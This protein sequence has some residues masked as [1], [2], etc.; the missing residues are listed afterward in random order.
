MDMYHPV[1]VGQSILKRMYIRLNF[2]EP[3][4]IEEQS[5]LW[6]AN[7]NS[8]AIVVS[9]TPSDM[10]ILSTKRALIPV[11]LLNRSLEGYSYVSIDHAEAGR[12][13]A[14]HAIKKGGSEISLILTSIPLN[15]F[16]AREQAILKTCREFEVDL[17]DK[18][19][20]A[21]GHIDAGYEL[22]CHLVRENRLRKVILCTYDMT[23]LGLISALNES[24]VHVGTDVEVLSTSS[25]LSRLFARFSP[26]MTVVN[27]KM[28]EISQR[29]VRM[30]IDLASGRASENRGVIIHPSIVYRQSSPIA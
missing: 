25:G 17:K 8:A 6:T 14:T 18:V 27:L 16:D 22:G 2:Y 21:E 9:A 11:V 15:G 13:A 30:A 28:E 24:G 29:C 20:Y 10:Q 12:L 23:A 5:A 26:P 19:F 3:G 4:H 1:A 7:D